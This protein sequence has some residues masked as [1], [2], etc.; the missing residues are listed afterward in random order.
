MNDETRIGVNMRIVK[1]AVLG[2]AT[3]ALVQQG[4]AQSSQNT[5]TEPVALFEVQVGRIEDFLKQPKLA[6]VVN[7]N[8][9]QT[10]IARFRAADIKYDVRKTDSLVSPFSGFVTA[11]MRSEINAQCG[12]VRYGGTGIGWS[13][14]NL[15]IENAKNE[16]CFSDP[17]PRP[18][19]LAR[20]SYSFQRGKWVFKGATYHYFDEP[21][22]EK[23]ET[24][25]GSALDESADTY[26]GARSVQGREFNGGWRTAFL[27]E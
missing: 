2:L 8:N 25:I 6:L 22:N 5:S 14:E 9:G 12:N 23:P 16:P 19:I 10:F 24:Y 1:G 21:L 20:F 13:S 7:G 15:A 17:F 11:T 27:P 3:F 26:V 18:P 4:H